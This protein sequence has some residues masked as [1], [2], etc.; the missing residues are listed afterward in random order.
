MG[1]NFENKVAN[2]FDVD[3]KLTEEWIQK[4]LEQIDVSL[5][6]TTGIK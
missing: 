6:A 2:K 1:E 3:L 4:P 5:K